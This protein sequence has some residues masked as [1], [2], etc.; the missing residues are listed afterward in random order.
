MI[1]KVRGWQAHGIRA[2]P[3]WVDTR[4]RYI[5]L[6]SMI[7]LLES[8]RAEIAQ[9]RV[10]PSRIVTHFDVEEKIG[11]SERGVITELREKRHSSS[12]RGNRYFPSSHEWWCVL[13][14]I[15]EE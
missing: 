5:P 9:R 13:I 8:F 11:R 6:L 14:R 10:Q 12:P 2:S 1:G 15:A 3:T 7:S 4:S